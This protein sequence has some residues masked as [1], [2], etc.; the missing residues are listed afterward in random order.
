MG[1]LFNH[2]PFVDDRSGYVLHEEV[3]NVHHLVL[4]TTTIAI[5]N[6]SILKTQA[7]NPNIGHTMVPTNYQTTWSQLVKSI[8][9]N[10]T[11]MLLI[12]T[13]PMWYMLTSR[14]S[15]QVQT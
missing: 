11:S 7:M 9:L 5:P 12:S 14:R 2:C 13:C 3:M 8:V 1:H 6:V 4:P 15:T 10:K